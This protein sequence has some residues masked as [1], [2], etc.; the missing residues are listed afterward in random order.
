[1]EFSKCCRVEV[2]V[3][4]GEDFG[5]L[6]DIRT[7]HNE[8][9]KCGQACDLWTGEEYCEQCNDYFWNEIDAESIRNYGRCE[10]CFTL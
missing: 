4:C 1:M 3:E 8:C 5:E 2:K 9:M 6:D 10:Y 7:C